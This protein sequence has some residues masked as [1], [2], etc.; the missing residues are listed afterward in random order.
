MPIV[1][2]NKAERQEKVCAAVAL[3][4]CGAIA[5][6]GVY[7]ALPT[8]Q[9]FAAEGDETVS[10]APLPGALAN[11]EDYV[12]Y[13]AE[14]N[15]N[16]NNP[17]DGYYLY[18][19]PDNASIKYWVRDGFTIDLGQIKTQDGT[20]TSYG[21]TNVYAPGDK[22]VF[23]E[24]LTNSTVVEEGMQAH[25]ND[26]TEIEGQK[27]QTNIGQALNQVNLGNLVG[28]TN[29]VGPNAAKV[30]MDYS[31]Y[32]Q[33]SRGQWVNVGLKHN[34]T[35]FYNNFKTVDNGLDYD[36]H[37][38]KY[39][40]TNPNGEKKVVDFDNIYY[41]DVGEEKPVAGVFVNDQGYLYEGT[42]WGATGEILTTA[43]DGDGL[44]TYWSAVANADDIYLKDS[45]LTVGEL[46]K[47]FDT[48]ETNDERLYNNDI[49]EITVKPGQ[50]GGGTLGLLR[51]GTDENGELVEGAITVEGVGGTGGDDTGIKFSQKDETG[52]DIQ[53]SVFTI[54][55]GS[56]VEGTGSDPSETSASQGSLTGLTINGQYYT[57]PEVTVSKDD[58]T[59]NIK[60]GD[61]TNID[62]IT[63][64]GEKHIATSGD[65]DP[66]N[67]NKPYTGVYTA[68]ADGTVELTEVDG[69]G[70][71]T[72]NTLQIKDVASKTALDKLDDLAVKYDDKN[73]DEITLGGLGEDGEPSKD[74][75]AIH[76]VANGVGLN[77]AVNVSQLKKVETLA[78]KHTTMTVNGGT[79]APAVPEGETESDYTDG[80]LQLK[81]TNNDGKIQY[82]VKLNDRIELGTA[83]A[84]GTAD[85]RVVV[86]GNTATVSIGGIDITNEN[87]PYLAVGNG[88]L[89]FYEDGGLATG[90]ETGTFSVRPDGDLDIT[91]ENSKFNVDAETGNVNAINSSGSAIM[92]NDDSVALNASGNGVVISDEGITLNTNGSAV[93]VDRF[94]GATFTN[95]NT[96]EST[97]INGATITTG[98]VKG[99]KN[100]T[101]KYEG[102]ATEGRAATEEQLQQATAASKTTLSNGIN[103]NVTSKTDPIDG[104]VDYQVNLNDNINLNNRVYI[105]G[106]P[107]EGNNTIID[108]KSGDTSKEES[109]FAVEDKGNGSIS[110]GGIDV[111]NVDGPYLAVGDGKLKFYKDGGLATG[112]E[113]GTFSVRP[114]G[115][116]EISGKNSSFNVDAETGN[117][118]AINSS[119][120]AIMMNDDSVALNAS[121]NGVVISDEGITLNT[122]GSA[123]T[124]DRFNGATF[125]N[126]N[127]TESTNINGATITTGTVKGLKNTTIKYEGFATEGRAAT[128]EQLQQATAASKT[129]LS[130]GINTNVT[131][132]TDPIDGHVDYQVNLNDNINLNN[133][134]Y[135]NGKPA[136]GNNTIIDIKSGDTSKEE[137]IFAVEDKGN[138]SISIG[139]IDVTN[140]DGPYLAVG[141]GKLKFYKDGGLATGNETGT[142]SVRP[143]GDLEIS[144]KNSSFN[145]DAETGNVNAINSSG[146]AIMMNDD[147]VALNASG[148][149]VVIS[150]EGITLNT[151]GSAVT[152]DRFN[153]ATFTNTNTTESTNINGATIT[154]GTVKGL[155]NTTI[156]YEGF[157]TEGRAATEEQLQQATA[158]SKTTLSNGINTNVT[159]KTDPID[160]HVDYQVNLNDNINLNNRVYINGK[161][162]EGN[163]TIIDIKS[164]D[165]SK[166]ESIFAVEDKGNG[167]ISIGGIDV[168]NVDGP[169]LAV[170]D[171]KLKFYK[172]GGLAT[173][174]ETGTFS[175]RPD[176]DLEI[177]GKNSS[178]NVDAETGN[179]N[180]INSS[181]SAIMMNDDSVALNA[182]GN[183]V[184]ISDEGITLNTNGSAVTVDRFNGATFTNTNTTESTN[185]NG[186]NITAGEGENQIKIN[187]APKADDPALSVGTDKFVVGQDGSLSVS[188]KFNVDAE[189]GNINAVNS[190]GSAIMMN[191]DSVALN[192][193]GNGVVISDEGIT[194]NT[195]GS[196]V[197]VDRF[198]GATF[199]NTNT[200][201]TTNINGDIITT[202]T[203]K[204]LSNTTW[205]DEL[206]T[207][208]ANSEE[209][210]GTAATQGQLQQAVSAV[211]TEAAKQH[212]TVSGDDNLTVKSSVNKN[213]GTN[214]QVTLNDNITLGNP[215]ADV[216]NGESATSI[217]LNTTEKGYVPDIYNEDTEGAEDFID[218]HGGFMFYATNSAGT[219]L[220]GVTTD[221]MAHAKDFVS[222][223]A[224]PD[225][226]VKDEV[227]Y[228]LNEI[229]DTVSQMATYYKKDKEGNLEHSYTVF[230]H[231][232]NEAEKDNPFETVDKNATR[233]IPLALRDDGAVLI[234]AT[235]KGDDFTDNG[236]RINAEIDDDGN[237]VATITGLEN[238]TWTPPAPVATFANEGTETSRAATEA[239]LNDL[240]GTVVGYNVDTNGVNYGTVTLGGGRTSYD[241]DT[242]E[243]GTVLNNVAYASGTDGSEA[244]NVDYL[245]DTINK[246]VEAGGSI[247]NSDKHLV[248]NTAEGS[249]GVYKPNAEGNV[250]LIVSDEKGNSSTVTIGDVASKTELDSLKTN[251]GDLNYDKVTGDKLVNGDSVTTAI[252]KLDNK[253]DNISG[254]ATDAANNTVTGGTI[255]D[256]GTISLTQK[257]GGTVA[258]DGK[259]TDSGVVQDGTKF[260]GETGTLT[261]TS[262]DKYNK[263]TSSVTVS[264]IASKNDIG[265]VKD[266]IGATSKE[267]LKDAYK[268][269]D[270]DGNATTEYITDSETMV[271]ADVALDHAVQD[272]ANTSYAND[273][274]LSNRIDNVESR[275]GD[276]EERIDKVGA[277][278]AAIANLRTMGYDPEAPTEVAVGVGQYKSETGIALGI[279]H[280]P[281]QDFML[282]A[283]ISTSGDEVMGG[284]GATWRI[285]RKTAE[286][287][288][289]DEEERILAKAE[290]I[291]QAAKR[292]EVKEQAER[293]AKLL[294]E[295]EAKGEPIVPVEESAEQAQA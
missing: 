117:V 83:P 274:I 46:N 112:N 199:T 15:A 145:V 89:K 165:T 140:V 262:Q 260:D 143:D 37:T 243:G 114:D 119:G 176:G 215:K 39:Y 113:T 294:A 223:T 49:K 169:Y 122:N 258:L 67:E 171:G 194:L 222:Y 233:D 229:G 250:N 57:V 286:E 12:A 196:A 27:V 53:D 105:N 141:D 270:K 213:G 34:P 35:D 185:I 166:E 174:N 138:G 16:P 235:I 219:G 188:D 251:V 291:K 242:H 25:R 52:E 76:N 164:G 31:Y 1:A 170:G 224:S 160:G 94:N 135:I 4:V 81:Q 13:K 256:D 104:H 295:R 132:K 280:Y 64:S 236:I 44:K 51:N 209:L 183:G 248:A 197:T 82:D 21:I 277:M 146:S 157:A 195:N 273:M 120:S 9:A 61:I 168:T 181:G 42:V 200:G 5:A 65:T 152:V 228:S 264:G 38:G 90:N 79:P 111:T 266:T 249:N 103:T 203:V 8:Q 237:N 275:L 287:K 26:G 281:N 70:K 232:L 116:L 192:A 163:N 91:G 41:I 265:T 289:K 207:Q 115:D 252:G 217:T 155:K 19:D 178:F 107:A 95:T 257:D 28:S 182:S 32:I 226:T 218:E 269:A 2:A 10:T 136:E 55:T 231:Y 284:I 123:V 142:F 201:E 139:G 128:E 244:V 173:G 98:T 288:A 210:Q 198:N 84:E 125:T 240:Y 48:L 290:E 147:S 69:T 151:N 58:D 7:G 161:P 102:F 47:A 134:V 212:T 24:V 73:K 186:A 121:G 100:T 271:D 246:A 3:V 245:K 77:D 17:P 293:H 191:D 172:D 278:A 167:S 180:A 179:V 99:L 62:L 127:T 204:G 156:K 255:K 23:N 56:R 97:N 241:Q 30:P 190:N 109:I 11:I 33:N 216:K 88:K 150:D 261:I 106:K 124:V 211:A 60:E 158:A 148:N 22:G 66:D 75:V 193:S 153:G 225:P 253:I 263:G 175:V 202:D 133:R 101:I 149:G 254:T 239:Q 227:R 54:N 130:N 92:M 50:N 214:Y 259:L 96:T 220:F 230:S 184:V 267:D 247:S 131:S 74:P 108:I 78:G 189:T 93:T 85:K 292:A 221:G 154:T 282:S 144:G 29:A 36:E 72:E 45:N 20:G 71:A 276:V 43:Q 68:D 208:V 63:T 285:G 110:I 238:T 40:Y 268:D 14:S 80:N 234:G 118:N 272:V 279:F 159:S 6:L 187:G 137:S 86:D 205:D 206:A 18:T 283:S 129:T 177:S 162:A 87:G 126:T 59:V